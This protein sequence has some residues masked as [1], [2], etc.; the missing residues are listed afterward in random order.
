MRTYHSESWPRKIKWRSTPNLLTN[1]TSEL[2][3]SKLTI[4]IWEQDLD[5]LIVLWKHQLWILKSCQES[6]MTVSHWEQ[7]MVLHTDIAAFSDLLIEHWVVI[8]HT[9]QHGHN[10]AAGD[11]GGK[12]LCTRN[13]F[14]IPLVRGEQNKKQTYQK[15]KK[16]SRYSQSS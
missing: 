16:E 13:D 7:N 9:S 12:Y 14:K 1:F 11:L 8:V 10:G 2:F 4:A 15:K 5:L 3:V 6:K